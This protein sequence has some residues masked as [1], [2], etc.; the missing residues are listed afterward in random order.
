M[1]K[2][3]VSVIATQERVL[4]ER[5]EYYKK[6]CRVYYEISVTARK[7]NDV[8]FAKKCWR[9][10]KECYLISIHAPSRERQHQNKLLLY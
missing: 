10:S 5:I 1:N 8:K 4:F 3:E 6:M 7:E 2:R 9:Y